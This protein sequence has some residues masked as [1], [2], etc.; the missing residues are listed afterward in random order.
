MYIHIME[1]TLRPFPSN[2]QTAAIYTGNVQKQ[3]RSRVRALLKLCSALCL[4]AL[5]A[6]AALASK[7]SSRFGGRGM[8]SGGFT[9]FPL[10]DFVMKQI[11]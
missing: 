1:F 4:K 10:S 11:H 3:T 5:F 8:S 6:R 9:L 2:I 7:L